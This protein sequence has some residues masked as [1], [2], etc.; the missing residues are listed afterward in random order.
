[1]DGEIFTITPDLYY[2]CRF[3]NINGWTLNSNS[4]MNDLIEQYITVLDLH[5]IGIAEAHLME[6]SMVCMASY[7]W[8]GLEI[9]EKRYMYMQKLVQE[10]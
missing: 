3:W 5:I 4:K 7:E 2:K 1:M 9:T 6:D 10:E 8:F